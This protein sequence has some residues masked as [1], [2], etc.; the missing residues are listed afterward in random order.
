MYN[1]EYKII[2]GN[3]I[4]NDSEVTKIIMLKTNLQEVPKMSKLIQGC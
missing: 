1:Q 4:A 3:W 2:K